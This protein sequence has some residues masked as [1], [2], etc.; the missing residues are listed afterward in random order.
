M[1]VSRMT[2]DSL[3]IELLS[4]ILVL[5]THGS[6]PADGLAFTSQSVAVPLVLGSVNHHWRSVA[7]TTPALWTS[8]CATLDSLVVSPDRTSTSFD[9]T[10]LTSYL[11]LSRQYPLDL[12]IDARDELWDYSEPEYAYFFV[13]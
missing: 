10:H 3:P 7:L 4:Y 5:A 8:L 12:V 2:I 11:R 6:R 13:R 1:A 9:T